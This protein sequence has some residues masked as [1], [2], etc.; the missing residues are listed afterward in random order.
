MRF[1]IF[2][3]PSFVHM[4]E[5][6]QGYVFVRVVPFSMEEELWLF[7]FNYLAR[8]YYWLKGLRL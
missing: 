6:P 7:P 1:R 2:I 5:D 4:F 8:F 3:P